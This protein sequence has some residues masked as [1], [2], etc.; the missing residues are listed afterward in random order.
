[1]FRTAVLEPLQPFYTFS[2]G[3][4]TRRRRNSSTQNDA[5][6]TVFHHGDGVFMVM[7]SVAFCNYL[8]PIRLVNFKW[9]FL[10][11]FKCLKMSA[12]KTGLK[13]LGK[14]FC[15]CSEL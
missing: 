4:L 6:V 12:L 9:N 10:S 11:H 5:A 2:I 14:T 3:F 8:P 7:H 15:L 1:M 13:M